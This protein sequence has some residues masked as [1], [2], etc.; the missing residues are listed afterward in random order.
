MRIAEYH[1]DKVPHLGQ[2]LRELVTR[3]AL[4]I[5]L[6]MQYIEENCKSSGGAV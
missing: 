1:P 5:N 6:A 2:E 4:E 3:K